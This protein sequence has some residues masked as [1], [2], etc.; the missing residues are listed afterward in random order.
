MT[1]VLAGIAWFYRSGAVGVG[2]R[3][4][5]FCRGVGRVRANATELS[6]IGKAGVWVCISRPCSRSLGCVEGDNDDDRIQFG[7]LAFVGID[8][9]HVAGH[10][11]LAELDDRRHR[12]M[13]GL[14]GRRIG[15]RQ[16]VGLERVGWNIAPSDR[17]D[18]G[19]LFEDSGIDRRAV[20]FGYTAAGGYD[21]GIELR[22]E[23]DGAVGP[24][25]RSGDSL[26][27][28]NRGVDPGNEGGGCIGLAYRSGVDGSGVGGYGVGGC[29]ACRQ[30]A[31]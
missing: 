28:D 17:R 7:I 2:A 14:A 26:R 6:H 21:W 13:K 22:L 27:F 5:G 29:G 30:G 25:G 18:R 20:G 15:S 4:A 12:V 11:S 16:R 31:Y 24:V 10:P 3:I 23:R 19:I 9:P 1:G 8:D